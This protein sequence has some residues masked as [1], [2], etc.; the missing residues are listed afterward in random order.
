MADISQAAVAYA[1]AARP[2]VLRCAQAQAVEIDIC[3]MEQLLS[4]NLC[5]SIVAC[6]M[7]SLTANGYGLNMH[8]LAVR[9]HTC[10]VYY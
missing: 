5:S 3:P 1:N 6:G 2:M 8:Y 7:Y 4:V 10:A 9:L